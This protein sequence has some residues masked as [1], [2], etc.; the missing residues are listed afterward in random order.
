VAS[1]RPGDRVCRPSGSCAAGLLKQHR[2]RSY[3]ELTFHLED[4]ASFRAFARLPPSW[5]P[6]KSVPQTTTSAIRAETAASSPRPSSSLIAL[7]SEGGVEQAPLGQ[8]PATFAK[9]EL[10]TLVSPEVSILPRH[11][12]SVAEIDQLEDQLYEYNHRMVAERR[13]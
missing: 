6:K 2:R 13:P 8:G 4:S 11:H 3:E 5:T 1:R 9:T 7:V 12:F 10:P